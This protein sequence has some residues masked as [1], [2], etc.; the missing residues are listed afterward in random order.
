M[1]IYDERVT[2]TEQNDTQFTHSY[3]IKPK[4]EAFECAF[5][6]QKTQH[7]GPIPCNESMYILNQQPVIKQG[8]LCDRGRETNG[9]Q[10]N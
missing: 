3:L 7:F 4:L 6:H 9:K 2:S 10:I 5:A 8:W 1:P